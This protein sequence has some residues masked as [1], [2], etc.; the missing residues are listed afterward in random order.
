MKV[1]TRIGCWY[2]QFLI[3]PFFQL[4]ILKVPFAAKKKVEYDKEKNP[5]D[6]LCDQLMACCR[7]IQISECNVNVNNMRRLVPCM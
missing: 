4:L 5:T 7:K 6:F 1:D 3:Q 2:I